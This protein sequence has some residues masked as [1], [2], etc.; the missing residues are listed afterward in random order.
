MSFRRLLKSS[1]VDAKL[2]AT[3]E[4]AYLRKRT[5]IKS[6]TRDETRSEIIKLE[7]EAFEALTLALDVRSETAVRVMSVQATGEDSNARIQHLEELVVKMAAQTNE[8]HGLHIGGKVQGGASGII[9]RA[10]VRQIK[11]NLTTKR[12][13]IDNEV[14]EE[15]EQAASARNDRLAHLAAASAKSLELIRKSPELLSAIAELKNLPKAKA[16]AKSAA[17]ASDE[18][19]P[20]SRAAKAAAKRAAKANGGNRH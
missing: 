4:K 15:R 11:A 6:N 12:E 18:I 10:Q 2:V 17:T 9:A 8:I 7:A 1:N 13:Q 3:W 5:A 20:V 16:K 19:A 14:K